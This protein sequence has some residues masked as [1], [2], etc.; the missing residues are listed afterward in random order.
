[1]SVSISVFMSVSVSVSPQVEARQF[2][3]TAHFSKKT[4]LHNYPKLVYKK[5]LQI[6][7]TLPDGGILVFLTGKREIMQLTNKLR[8]YFSRRNGP[9]VAIAGADAAATDAIAGAADAAGA[10]LPGMWDEEQEQEH[11]D[12]TRRGKGKG[13]GKGRDKDRD[14]DGDGQS[15]DDSF[16][17]ADSACGDSDEDFTS[18]EEEMDT[19]I[20]PAISAPTPVPAPVPTPAPVSAKG[21]APAPAESEHADERSA[22]L[23]QL[24][25]G[26][27]IHALDE[28]PAWEEGNDN[29]NSDINGNG[30]DVVEG[31]EGTKDKGEGEGDLEA[32]AAAE[33]EGEDGRPKNALVLPLFAMLSAEQQAQVFQPPP[34]GS[35]LIVV[36]TN[37]AETSITIPGVKYVVDCGRYKEKVVKSASGISKFEVHW[38][39]KA[40]ADQRMGRAGRTGPGHCYRLFSSAFYDQHMKQF[41]PPEILKTPLE[42]LLLQMRVLGIDDVEHFPFPTPPTPQAVKIALSTLSYIACVSAAA[43]AVTGLA[44]LAPAARVPRPLERI[45]PLGRLVALFP[46]GAR[47]AKML[48]VAHRCGLPASLACALVSVLTERPPFL[49]RR[50]SFS[51]FGEGKKEAVGSD[52]SGSDSEG[53]EGAGGQGKADDAPPLYFHPT[54]DALARLRAL[55]AY[56]HAS[57]QARNSSGGGKGG[58][59][60]R[61]RAQGRAVAAFCARHALHQPSLDRALALSRQLCGLYNS[62]LG[63]PSGGGGGD[64]DTEAGAGAGDAMKT[65][66]P[67]TEE[68]EV[69]LRQVGD[70]LCCV[71]L[72]CDMM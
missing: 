57:N 36:A 6:H 14:R 68:Q 22:L 53:E 37:V 19:D 13:R 4:D 59:K 60:E 72:C 15:S 63:A 29:S 5:V 35:R 48:V 52:N 12:E 2:P 8:R 18:D 50:N 23:R 54:S 24:L 51:L 43:P 42:D 62:T 67:P 20:A 7:K 58:A 44:A 69:A 66:Q 34:P 17:S 21:K 39:S 10:A 70:V 30:M 47:Y 38:V 45:T 11:D 56:I 27:G 31:A 26:G 33:E 25:M 61:E 1:M 55:G 3:V 65:L 32:I 41:Q 64:S 71:I 40:S 28:S 16:D 49:S 46:I 9:A